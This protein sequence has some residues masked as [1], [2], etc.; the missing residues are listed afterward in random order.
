MKEADFGVTCPYEGCRARNQVKWPMD[1]SFTSV[2][3]FALTDIQEYAPVA[4]L[5]KVENAR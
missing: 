4:G 2:P 3:I 1:G 5:P